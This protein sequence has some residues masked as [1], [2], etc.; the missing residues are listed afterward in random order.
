MLRAIIIENEPRAQ[1]LLSTILNEYCTDVT[2]LG[3]ANSPQLGVELIKK[4]QPDFIF[5]D[6]ELDQGTG[7]DLLNQLNPINFKVIFTTAFDHF[8]LDAFKYNTTD[9]ILKPYSPKEV[10]NAVE[11]IKNN[12]NHQVLYHELEEVILSNQSK[13]LKKINFPTNNGISRIEIEHIIRFE[14]RQS[15]CKLFMTNGTSIL[16]SKTLK[17]IEELL[18]GYHFFRIH[19]S[20]LINMDHVTHYF[21]E[22]GGYAQTSDAS[23]IPIARRRKQEFLNHL[24]N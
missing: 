16:V 13:G 8:A 21:K 18:S 24:K 9:Y 6:I 22:D 17:K 4:H 11:K 1:S 12:A 3:I 2:L 15:Y 7:F 5:L 20:H 10:L 23:K 14:A 19:S